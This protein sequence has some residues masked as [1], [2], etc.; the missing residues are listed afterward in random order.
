MA[1][2]RVQPGHLL[3]ASEGLAYKCPLEAKSLAFRHFPL[4]PGLRRIV[5]TE[6][7][8]IDAESGGQELLYTKHTQKIPSQI[9]AL[10]K[11]RMTV[12]REK[13]GSYQII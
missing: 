3:T 10:S 6:A 1:L 5:K 8:S 4:R 11:E 9:N 13:Y 2:T 7:E 12:E